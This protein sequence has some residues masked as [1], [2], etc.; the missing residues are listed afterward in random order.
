MYEIIY[1]FIYVKIVDLTILWIYLMK[2]G[3]VIYIKDIC[4]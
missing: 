1:I 3:K 4:I 2:K